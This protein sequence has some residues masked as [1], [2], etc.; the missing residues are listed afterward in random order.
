MNQSIQYLFDAL[1]TGGINALGALGIALIFGVMRLVNF[2]HGAFIAFCVYSLVLPSTEAAVTLMFG[3]LPAYFLIPLVVGLGMLVSVL[4]EALVF[5]HFRNAN[6]ATMMIASFTVGF[7][8][9]N[10]MLMSYGSRPKA[11]DLWPELNLPVEILGARVPELQLVTVGVSI[12][13]L[14]GLVA[15]LRYTRA[16]IEMRA[17]AED[18]TMARLLGVR[19]NRV[20]TWAFALSGGLAAAIGLIVIAQSGVADIRMGVPVMLTAFIAT[21]I[22]GLGSLSGAVTAG[23]AIGAL[24]VFLQYV[25]PIEA[26]PFRDAFVFAAVIAILIW[27]PQGLFVLKGARQ[28]V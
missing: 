13:G 19:A 25:L 2:A 3:A 16:G 17:A 8:I 27:R 21:V 26:R 11:I 12:L 5:R 15:L 7:V 6:P 1:S 20:I 18:F 9:Q 14:A 23:F 4:S 28:R 24:S 22:G 10:A